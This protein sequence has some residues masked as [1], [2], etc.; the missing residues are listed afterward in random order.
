MKIEHWVYVGIGLI[1][2]FFL[3]ICSGNDDVDDKLILGKNVVNNK[4]KTSVNIVYYI[5]FNRKNLYKNIMG[6]NKR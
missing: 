2:L 1:C 6:Y 4:G 5:D 3:A